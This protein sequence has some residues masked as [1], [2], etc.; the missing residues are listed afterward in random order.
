MTTTERQKAILGTLAINPTAFTDVA[1]LV[2]PY[3]FEDG[4]L[5]KVANLIWEKQREGLQYDT[6]SLE[7]VCDRASLNMI[8]DSM[9][10]QAQVVE[11]A[12]DVRDNYFAKKHIEY[13]REMQSSLI[14]GTSYFNAR[15]QY[16]AKIEAM[17]MGMAV[18]SSKQDRLQ[19]VLLRTER[20]MK[21][22]SVLSGIPTPYPDMNK[23]SGGWQK[24][25]YV[26]IGARPGMGK[27][28]FL[29]EMAL[30]A[31]QNERPTAFFSLGDLTPE[32]VYIKMACITAGLPMKPVRN[33]D[34]SDVEY[35]K[36]I[37]NVELLSNW[38]I[39]VIGLS[40]IDSRIGAIT[41]RIHIGV[42]KEGWEMAII[43]YIGQ[44]SP[45]TKSFSA[46][47]ALEKVSK[48]IQKCAKS[49]EIPLLVASQLNRAVETR[50]GSKRPGLSDLRN[51]GALEQDADA[52]MFLYRP[53]YYGIE[54]NEEG[55]NVKW[56]TEVLVEKY[57]IAGDEVPATFNLEWRDQRL[58]QEA[59]DDFE[60]PIV[61]MDNRISK[62]AGSD[63]DIPF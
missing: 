16:N 10:S 50:G 33:G 59:G 40:D 31:I 27:T 35:E 23:F 38:P 3:M 9:T 63:T 56:R 8:V 37:H 58:K 21:N 6:A 4:T 32:D 42:E 5:Q 57:R 12:V 41:D 55:E 29:C 51:S 1:D 26:I 54:Y 34:I 11:H 45:D 22:P 48:Q 17:L 13:Q 15:A 18:K 28:T 44:I 7:K 25:D 30:S 24:G 49:H 20:I 60:T 52:V 19:S 2:Q 14:E 36:F 61:Q 47:D 62:T 53:G 46:N 39:E 43:D